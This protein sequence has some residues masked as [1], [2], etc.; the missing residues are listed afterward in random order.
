MLGAEGS[1]L[2]KWQ[3]YYYLFHIVWPEKD[4]RTVLVHRAKNLLGPWEGKVV[5]RDK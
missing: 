3:E 2:F 1:Q 4:M 5:L